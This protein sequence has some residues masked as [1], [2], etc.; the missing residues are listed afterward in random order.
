LLGQI[1]PVNGSHRSPFNGD[2]NNAQPRIGFAYA[3]NNK[4]SIRAAYGL[5]YTVNRDQ[6]KGEVGHLWRNDSG[7]LFTRDG[8]YTQYATLEN[9][10]PNGLTP[11]P[12]P[13]Y[14]L[15]YMGF[16]VSSINPV[17]ANPQYQQWN[18]SLQREV[19]GQ[20]VLEVNY[21]AS[22]GH[23]LYSGSG[24]YNLM[25]PQYYGLGRTALNAQVPNPFYGLITDPT[26]V[27][28]L[29]TVAL[30][31]L[32]HPYPQ[33]GGAGVG[34]YLAPQN[35]ANSN[36][37]SVQFK[38]EKRF[39]SGL[40]LVAHYTISKM[41]SDGDVASGD[42][43]FLGGNASVQDWFNRHLEKSISTFDVPQRFVT[44]FDYQLPIGRGKAL[45]RNMNKVVN[46]FVGGWE[47]GGVVTLMKAMPL[48]PTLASSTLWDATQR[49]NLIANPS[50]PG[51]IEARMN[52]YFNVNAFSQPVPD[53][54]G[55]ASR[56]LP[57]YRG[58]GTKNADMTFMK[59]F[60]ITEQKRVQVRLEA[61]NATNT[62]HWA[63]PNI[64]YGSTSFGIIS[65]ASN[66]RSVQ[67]AAK[68]YW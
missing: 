28:S 55:T 27:E 47:I 3:L 58:P 13:N 35:L 40:S 42:V 63:N 16:G 48:V 5:F 68:F 36:Y 18:F 57:S 10:F 17:S 46:G 19:R 9:P 67:V 24:N 26:T 8:G 33:Y 45:G 50:M 1:I 21:S 37:Q 31:I 12:G 56:T 7:V 51:S 6:V 44:S 15:A 29:P 22:A 49:P 32:L 34:G 53:T 54:Y 65:S 60:M 4:T 59:N 43:N 23:H 20:G 30:S 38:Y 14:P 62:P 61:Y 64:S 39:S 52:N 25:S 11:P 2:Y 66:A 41:M